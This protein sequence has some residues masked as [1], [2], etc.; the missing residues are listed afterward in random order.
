M[1]PASHL[2]TES[3]RL[4]LRCYPNHVSE[5]NLQN[6][7]PASLP[8][9]I[10]LCGRWSR[11]EPLTVAQH[12]HAIWSAVDGYDSVWSWLGDGPYAY[13]EEFLQAIRA[14][15]AGT[16]AQFFAICPKGLSGEVESATGYGQPHED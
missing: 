11:L 7:K 13:E 14:K 5:S 12:G 1:P 6:W 10:A 4:G 9:A 8:G 2:L 15:E 16:S 3:Q